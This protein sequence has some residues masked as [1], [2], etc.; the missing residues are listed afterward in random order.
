MG[1]F[2]KV[3]NGIVIQ[4]ISA[5]PEFMPHYQDPDPTP[6]EWIQTSYNTKGGVHYDP[7]T[8]EPSADQSKALRKNFAGIGHI[9]DP[10]LDAFYSP[11][12]YDSW[13]LDTNTCWWQAP[14]PYPTDGNRYI[15]DENTQSWVEIPDPA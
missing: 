8:G 4:V 1:S 12:P 10:A 9:Y 7:N 5:E 6:G 14:V 3:S 11:K 2:A 15:W 13:V